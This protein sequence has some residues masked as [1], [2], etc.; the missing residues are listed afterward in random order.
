MP[1]KRNKQ[2]GEW[3][4]EPDDAQSQAGT[5]L[6]D[7]QQPYDIQ[8]RQGQIASQ[9]RDA[10]KDAQDLRNSQLEEQLKQSQLQA[11]KLKQQEN[12]QALLKQSDAQK[13]AAD[14]LRGVIDKIDEVAFDAA[15]NNG[16]FETGFTGSITRGIPGTAA[17]DLGKNIETIDANSAF[18]RLAEMRNNS[19]TGGA[20]GQVTERELDLLKSSIANIN[21]NQSQDQFFGNLAQAKQRYLDM[22]SRIDPAA[23]EEYGR[24][25]GIRF[26]EQGQP[27]LYSVDGDDDR[28]AIDPFGVR[29]GGGP[30]GGSPSNG[31]SPGPMSLDTI[32]KGLGRGTGDIVESVGDIGGM[33]G[34]NLIGTGINRAFGYDQNFDMG[35]KLR[36]FT[37]LPDN[38]DPYSSA[39]NKG[40]AAALTGA[41]AARAVSSMLQGAPRQVANIVGQTPLRDMVAGGS[42]GLSSEVAR[43]NDVG[44]VGQLAAGLAGGMAGYGG[45]SALARAP[46]IPTEFANAA[47][48]Q[49][50]DMLPADAGGVVPKIMT[51]ASRTSPISASPV[52]NAAQRAQSQMSAAARRA[53]ESQGP[54]E[55]TD[56]AGE[57]VRA[58]AARHTAKTRDI[59]NT[60]YRQ[61]YKETAGLNIKS[62]R[63]VAMIDEQI[64]ALRQAP[65]TNSSAINELTRLRSDLTNGM[66]VE[67][68]HNLRSTISS[69]VFDG[70]LRSGPDKARYKAIRAA[71]SDDMFNTLN[72]YGLTNAANKLRRAD[73]YWA[74]RVEQIDQVLQPI[75]G[76]EGQKG[77]EQIVATLESMA[78][79]N[80][81]GNKRL[82]RLMKE[83]TPEE[84]GQVRAVVVDRL[85]RATPG[86]QTAEGTA[87]SAGT[88]LT[89][90]NRMT[91]QAKQTMFGDKSLRQNLDDIALLAERMKA[92]QAMA[93]HSNTGAAMQGSMMVQGGWAIS[94]L[95]SYL[96]G[97]GAQF[98]TGRMMASPRFANWLA[99]AP[100]DPKRA[101]T[102]SQQLGVI[103]GREPFIAGDVRRLQ[104][105]LMQS[106]GQSPGRAAAEEE[107]NYRR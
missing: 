100:A 98:L 82:S 92:S 31:P 5:V 10:Q 6:T 60:L 88:F 2:T 69:G 101:R 71:I 72:S 106:F 93:N 105:H 21:P 30:S 78:R 48:R 44:P 57:A 97:A 45:A 66:T 37:G 39:I 18:E 65:E 84:A 53:A 8:Y 50:V 24:K 11:A 70:L 64:A 33:L 59:G 28:E 20:L 26:D 76:R 58:A 85:G 47:N 83:M 79:G 35:S 41:G 67:G 27:F 104:E 81:G 19:P 22:L 32:M 89:N 74:Q 90:W 87:F 16:W 42:A 91:P 96:L 29:G 17:Y 46:R 40:G 80:A 55:T 9:G 23:A 102:Y 54:I 94:H 7:P 4:W 63:A 15:D 107:E 61:A 36:E 25:R 77:G 38:P 43:Q 86:Q 12:Q 103:A 75:I 68:L 51:T 34:G 52:A 14:T 56:L 49:G 1:Y 99:K 3:V 73:T 62:P 13:S 95:P